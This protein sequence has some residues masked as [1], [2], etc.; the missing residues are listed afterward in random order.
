MGELKML[1]KKKK[2]KRKRGLFSDM[3][4][5]NKSIK[6]QTVKK[7]RGWKERKRDR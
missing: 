4:L 6:L 2:E 1:E 7:L 3:M 5:R